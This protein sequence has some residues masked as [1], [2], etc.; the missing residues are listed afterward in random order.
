MGFNSAFK[1]LIYSLSVSQW[2]GTAEDRVG[3]P[4]NRVRFVADDVV[5]ERVFL[6]A[7]SFLCHYHSSIHLYLYIL[8]SA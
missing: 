5:L 7:L 2:P 1:G 8:V 4:A 3:P 6:R